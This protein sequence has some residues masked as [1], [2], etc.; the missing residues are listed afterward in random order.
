MASRYPQ[1]KEQVIRG[2]GNVFAD[3]GFADG[4]ERQAKPSSVWPML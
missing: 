4:A 1:R 2:T 3:L